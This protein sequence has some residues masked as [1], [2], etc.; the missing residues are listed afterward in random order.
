LAAGRGGRVDG[1]LAFTRTCSL[2]I[3]IE[4]LACKGAVLLVVEVKKRL[5]NAKAAK[6]MAGLL[7]VV[8]E[9]LNP[10]LDKMSDLNRQKLEAYLEDLCTILDEIEQRE[11][12]EW[13]GKA[14]TL[15]SANKSREYL[16]LVYGELK[17]IVSVMTL[18]SVTKVAKDFEEMMRGIKEERERSVSSQSAAA[19]TAAAAADS[20]AAA[21]AAATTLVSEVEAFRALRLAASEPA[22]KAL[23]A[24]PKVMRTNASEPAPAISV[25]GAATDVVAAAADLVNA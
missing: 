6:R 7:I 20:A 18:S 11:D 21:A 4:S 3:M 16:E 19:A 13:R 23:T 24:V 22:L 15:W 9:Q 25:V 1:W 2:P 8:M 5:K 17:D 10:L 12:K 14:Q